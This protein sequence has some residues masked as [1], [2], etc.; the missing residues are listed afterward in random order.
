M[1]NQVKIYSIDI[2]I[3]EIKEGLALSDQVTDIKLEMQK[4]SVSIRG[5]DVAFLVAIVGATSTALGAL[6]SGVIQVLMEKRKQKIVIQSKD[7]SRIEVPVNISDERL[8]ELVK[9]VKKMD[10]EIEIIIP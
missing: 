7:G 9:Q 4:S 2:P 10:E 1:S 5:E 3:Q 8:S 6:I